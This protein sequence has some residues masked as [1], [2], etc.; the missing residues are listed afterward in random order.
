MATQTLV[1][2]GDTISPNILPIPSN[3]SH[4]LKLGPGLR[5]TPP[6]TITS[7][8]AGSLCIDPK[9]NAIWVENNSGR[10]I[11]QPHDLILATVHHSSTDWYHCAITPYTTLAQLPHL[12]FEGATKKTRPQLNAGSLVYARVVSAA[13]HTDVEITCCNA[14]T[15]KSEGMGELKGGMVFD[16]SLGMA[17]RLLLARQREEGGIV[18]LEGLA[19]KVAFEVAVGRNGKVWVKSGGVKETLLVGRALQETDREGLGVEEQGR[20][21]KKLLRGL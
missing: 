1:L 20:L 13:K 12:A 10:Y 2:P 21:V 5:H 19:E 17:R 6:S 9:K 15:G 8:L 11:P 3:P 18:V 14:S 4:F 7:V 16:V